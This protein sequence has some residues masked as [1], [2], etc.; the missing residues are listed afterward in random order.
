MKAPQR[1]RRSW[2]LSWLRRLIVDLAT[3]GTPVCCLGSLCVRRYNQLQPTVRS[4]QNLI[5]MTG[6]LCSCESVVGIIGWRMGLFGCWTVAEQVLDWIQDRGQRSWVLRFWLR[7][8]LNPCLEVLNIHESS[9]GGYTHLLRKHV[10]NFFW[11]LCP[12]IFLKDQES[13]YF[14]QNIS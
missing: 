8:W 2:I 1:L 12:A 5:C 10:H 14:E 11:K 6:T 9:H 3:S 7:I 13:S 4:Q